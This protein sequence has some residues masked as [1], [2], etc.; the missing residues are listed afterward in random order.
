[1]EVH[2]TG[3][4]NRPTNS[5]TGGA[6][7][8]TVTQL[9]SRQRQVVSALQECALEAAENRSADTRDFTNATCAAID[10]LGTLTMIQTPEQPSKP[11]EGALYA[12]DKTGTVV[13]VSGFGGSTEHGDEVFVACAETRPED[14][15]QGYSVPLSEWEHRMIPVF[16]R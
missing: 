3:G 11:S 12:D 14:T 1:M 8:P 9:I 13:R 6:E 15:K 7:V 2:T 16:Q 5:T 4:I 10:K